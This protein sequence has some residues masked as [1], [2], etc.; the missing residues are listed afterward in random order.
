MS[1]RA[2]Y[3]GGPG[4]TYRLTRQEQQEGVHVCPKC[5]EQMEKQ[6]FT[7]NDK[8]LTCPGCGF[9]IPTSKVVDKK[10]EIEIEPDGSVE[11]EVEPVEQEKEASRRTRSAAMEVPSDL[12][13][14]KLNEIAAVIS[15]DWTRVNFAAKPYLEAM[16]S[17]D[18]VDDMYGMDTG[19]S[20]VLYFLSNARS[21]KGDVAKAVKKELTKRTK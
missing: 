18:T 16:F 6:K 7:K 3:W 14:M 11:V 13:R 12:N 9:K 5:R 20:I 1:R 17:L 2:L 8:L 21:W 19:S 15:A 10:I 4:R